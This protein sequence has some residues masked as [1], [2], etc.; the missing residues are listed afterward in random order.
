[1]GGKH[2]LI[3][4]EPPYRG[5]QPYAFVCYAHDDKALVYPQIA[6]LQGQGINIWYDEGISAGANW[7]AVIGD[8]LDQASHVIFFISRRSL[9]SEHCNRE[10]NLALDE[11]KGLVP[12][13]LETTPL[14]ADLKIGLNRIHALTYD[15][16][17]GY[18]TKL[19]AALQPCLSGQ[20]P[21]DSPP[22]RFG[23]SYDSFRHP[24]RFPWITILIAL[25]VF[26]VG[27]ATYLTVPGTPQPD[28]ADT[29]IPP[30]SVAVL[31]FDNA[32]NNPDDDYLSAG[33][34]DELR[35]QLGQVPELLIAAR[36]SSIAVHEL[37]GD[38]RAR[39]K[40]LGVAYIVEGTLR[41]QGDVLRGSVQLI[42]GSNGLSVWTESF[43]RKPDEFL[44]LQ[45][46]IVERLVDQI[47]PEPV[48]TLPT[49]ATRN[50]TA[51]EAL[52]LGRYYEQQVRA[53]EEVDIQLLQ[54]AIGHYRDAVELDPESALANSRLAGALLYGGNLDAAQAPI[55]KALSI[56][57]NLSEVQHT[58]GL[59]YL[60][61]GR[62]EAYTAF[63]RAVELDP[64][65]ADALASY[66]YLRWMLV[67]DE[68]DSPADFYRRALEIDRH[69]LARYG[70]YGVM[71][72]WQGKTEEVLALIQRIEQ[73]FDGADA[74][75]LISTLYQL[76][77]QLDRAIAWAIRARDLE[78]GNDDHVWQ[79]A[80]LY[81][82]IGDQDT[83]EALVPHPGI[84]LL[85]EMRRYPELISLA[86]KLVVEQQ[87]SIDVRYRLAF[88]YNATEDYESAMWVMISTGQPETTMTFPRSGADWQGFFTLVNAS[89]GL[90]DLRTA[91]E[92]AN[93]FVNEPIHH[94][95]PDWFTETQMA[96][97]LA[98]LDRDTEAL[99][100]L[101]TIQRSPRL[102]QEPVLE[103]STCL[104]KYHGNP[105]YQAVLEH[106]AA[107]QARLRARL[108]QTLAEFGVSL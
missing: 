4:P 95:N 52:L 67:K 21:T 11:G 54:K 69:S 87:G 53:S 13:Y 26:G 94:E 56:D 3:H 82:E 81:T 47:L 64:D 77:G 49:P 20:A 65:N 97:G 32:S 6:W 106:F 83:A 30:N 29:P 84:G 24:S 35:E 62:P 85:Y 28:V 59:Y 44:G 63:E 92:L 50:A 99:D 36:S 40:Q 18:R 15:S 45:Q 61:R 43:S 93:W 89:Y 98:V 1:M 38:V 9:R 58:L 25:A 88:A 105:R 100:T 5:D 60:A 96:C 46:E 48:E 2:A 31:P 79:L 73:R 108:P 102:P 55:F 7:R 42:D 17:D 78:P 86:E 12:V 22:I 76:I 80:E 16:S 107:R 75:R 27:L 19:L 51:N 101:E 74:Y 68:G 39:S 10:I 71:L 72:G 104:R 23:P 90:G 66:A 37:G 57:P 70:S 41:R 103:D 91:R 34:S 14:T 33:L 8:R